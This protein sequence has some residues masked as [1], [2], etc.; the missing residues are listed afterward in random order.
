MVGSANVAVTLWAAVMATTQVPVPLHDAP[1]QPVKAPVVAVAVRVTLVPGV[2]A[3]LQLV[4]QSMPPGAEVT[5]HWEAG[6][7]GVHAGTITAARA[8][9][10]RM[11]EQV[12]R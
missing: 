11:V 8:W 3:A 2:K 4:P 9:L 6:G 7:H 12:R 10:E 1:L 5:V